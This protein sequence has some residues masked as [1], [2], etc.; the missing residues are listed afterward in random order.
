MTIYIGL[1]VG[2]IVGSWLPVA[3][4]H[5]GWLSAASLIG[6]FVGAVLGTWLGWKLSQWIE[7]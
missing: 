3:L 1:F 5:Q 2:S 7:S 6:G 4:F